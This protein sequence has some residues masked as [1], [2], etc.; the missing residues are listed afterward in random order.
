MEGELM[1]YDRGRDIDRR[2][3]YLVAAEVAN[4]KDM[5]LQRA[6]TIA[7]AQD[8]EVNAQDAASAGLEQAVQEYEALNSPHAPGLNAVN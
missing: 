5:L 6:R 8:E 3:A 4:L 1:A 2:T 7:K